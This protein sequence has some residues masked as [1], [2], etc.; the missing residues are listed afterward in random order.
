MDIFRAKDAINFNALQYL[1]A[2]SKMEL[3][4]KIVNGR[5]LIVS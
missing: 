4:A 5:N 2:T 3:F 1:A